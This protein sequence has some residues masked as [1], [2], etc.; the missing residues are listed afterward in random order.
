MLILCKA[1]DQNCIIVELLNIVV[2]SF[3]CGKRSVKLIKQCGVVREN[4]TL[5][6]R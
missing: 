1:E 4:R 2:I 3:V 5:H 6:N